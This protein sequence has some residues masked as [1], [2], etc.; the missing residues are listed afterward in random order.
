MLSRARAG[1]QAK[2]LGKSPVVAGAEPAGKVAGELALIGPHPKD[3]NRNTRGRWT[4]DN[5]GHLETGVHSRRRSLLLSPIRLEMRAAILSDTGHTDNDVPRAFSIIV[6]QLIE[7]RLIAQS[8]FEFLAASGG[9]ITTKGRQRRCVEG[10]SRASD[11]VAKFASMVGL[12]RR[13]RRTQSPIEWLRSLDNEQGGNDDDAPDLT[14]TGSPITDAAETPN[15][16]DNP[17][18]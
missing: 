10:W 13:A 6:D 7:A 17:D 1:K 18:R 5:A 11:R 8:Y 12:E 15:I 3:A 9:P 14:E 4:P 2:S 16:D